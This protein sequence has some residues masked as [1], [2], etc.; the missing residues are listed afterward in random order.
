MKIK[1]SEVFYSLQGEGI[2]IGMPT[3][4]VRLFGCDLRCSWCDSMY[5]VEGTDFIVLDINQVIENVLSYQCV[6]V[7][8]TGGEP[9]LQLDQTVFLTKKFI[10]IDKRV[11][12]ETAG[13]RKPPDI[14]KNS[15]TTVSMDCK[16]PSSGMNLKSDLQNL[17]QLKSKD[18]IKF[19]IADNNDYVFAKKIVKQNPF[20]A[21]IIFQPAYGSKIS[22]I[23]DA[24]IKDKLRVRVLP[25]LHKDIWG[26]I[27][28]V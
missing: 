1:I 15:K 19:V 8:I 2:Q 23:A 16:C 4:F 26:D 24:V 28:G 3:V 6:N 17:I 14:F 13:H 21:E 25:Q 11:I 20:N 12:L 18:Q 10:E 22:E 27:K 9:L 7:C 5:A